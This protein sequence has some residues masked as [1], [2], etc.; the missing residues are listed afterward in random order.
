MA[1]LARW[2][3]VALVLAILCNGAGTYLRKVGWLQTPA[4][5]A[6]WAWHCGQVGSLEPHRRAL[7]GCC[8]H[9]AA[10]ELA[11][12]KAPPRRDVEQALASYIFELTPPEKAL[13]LV[14]DVF[15]LAFVAVSAWLLA[16]RKPLRVSLGLGSWGPRALWVYGGAMFGLS[17]AWHGLLMPTVGLRPFLFLAVFWAGAWMAPHLASLARF[18]ALALA[19]QLLLVP[20][21]LLAGIHVN[22][23]GHALHLGWLD[24][25]LLLSRASGTLVLPNSLGVFAVTAL[26]FC[27]AFAPS[28]ARLLA[29]TFLAMGLV[30]ASGSGAG[31]VGML[32]FILL[33]A[34]GAV[35]AYRRGWLAVGA[36]MG[37]ALLWGLLPEIL[38]R[39]D[40]FDSVFGRHGRLD[41]IK[42]TALSQDAVPLLFGQ[43]LGTGSNLAWNLEHNTSAGV[44]Q[45][46]SAASIGA[47]DSTLTALMIQLGAVGPL[48]FYGLLLWAAR[49]D[50]TARPFYTVLAL[51][52][53]AMN[54]TELF[55]VN[56]LLGLALAHSAGVAKPKHQS[57]QDA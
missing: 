8:A 13:K 30:Y 47:G 1:A 20:L 35:P 16:Q 9:A 32:L 3:G 12:M 49:R 31:A 45:A 17:W 6:Y 29:L 57:R 22:G 19:L 24:L 50:A 48:R 39:P 26:A 37:A 52:S 27:Q 38:G 53:L 40:I 46:P 43:G 14:K 36:A 51:C 42:E 56:F 18:V 55:P 4:Y 25:H 44:A 33:A 54:V 7:P 10:E 5:Q 23:H 11:Q 34:W 21:E 2:L 15:A 28:R 41:T